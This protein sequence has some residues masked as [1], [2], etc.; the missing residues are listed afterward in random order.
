MPTPSASAANVRQC[1]LCGDDNAC[2]VVSGVGTCW[3]ASVKVPE[4]VLA[5]VPPSLRNVACVCQRCATKS[6]VDGQP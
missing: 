3:C 4:T 2:G 5:R 1:P 6:S